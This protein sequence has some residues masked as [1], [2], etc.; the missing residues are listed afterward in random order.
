MP[1]VSRSTKIREGR[2]CR[3]QLAH[4]RL[5]ARL[6]GLALQLAPHEDQPQSSTGHRH[7]AGDA[8]QQEDELAHR[9]Q[10]GERERVV[11]QH[12]VHR[13]AL[14][15]AGYE[16]RNPGERQRVAHPESK[17][18]QPVLGQI[19]DAA[20]D[21]RPDEEGRHPPGRP[22]GRARPQRHEYPRAEVGQD[23]PR[24]ARQG[25]ARDPAG[26]RVT[27][28]GVA[29]PIQED[30]IRLG[31]GGRQL[32]ADHPA[33][34]RLGSKG[35]AQIAKGA[36]FV[37]APRQREQCQYPEHPGGRPAGVGIGWHRH[38][39]CAFVRPE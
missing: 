36:A 4:H 6:H 33:R 30:G 25:L 31:G 18:V 20:R 10:P 8:Q 21:E 3:L 7:R 35:F 1:S 29:A 13:D 5:Q 32:Q 22:C 15:Q 2:D 26:A 23:E 27:R 9:S 16:W 28:V 14:D 17:C 37:R 39:G 19:E 11:M 38:G 12:V 24:I 34:S